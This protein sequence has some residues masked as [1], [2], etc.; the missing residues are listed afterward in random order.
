MEIS[1]SIIISST[2][3]P[4]CVYKMIAPELIETEVPHYFVVVACHEDNNYMLMSTTQI[5][6]KYNY[7][8]GKEDMDTIANILP[9][10]SNGLTKSSFFDCNQHY[11]ITKSQLEIKILKQELIPSGNLS[12]EEF[13]I[14]LKSMSLSNTLDIPKFIIPKAL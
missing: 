6:S 4:G 13:Q 1:P 9:T 11:E 14:L 5:M 10:A 12:N 2:L 8:K 7:Y 3:R